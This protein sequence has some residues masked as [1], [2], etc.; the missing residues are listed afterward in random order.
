MLGTELDVIFDLALSRVDMAA[1]YA[2]E[3]VPSGS[4]DA[5]FAEVIPVAQQNDFDRE[6]G[7]IS[8]AA[9]K[10]AFENCGAAEGE[11]L[12]AEHVR[13]ISQLVMEKLRPFIARH[14]RRGPLAP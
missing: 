11:V 7:R 9:I 10:Y 6:R 5:A 1:C 13:K 4:I 2:G 3:C 14:V 12:T 8:N